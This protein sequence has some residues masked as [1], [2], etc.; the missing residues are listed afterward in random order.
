LVFALLYLLRSFF[1]LIF[2]TFIFSYIQASG[3]EKLASKVPN[4]TLRV[5]FVF[6]LFLGIIAAIFNFLAPRVQTQAEVFARKSPQYLQNLDSSLVKAASDYPFL[7]RVFPQIE[8]MRDADHQAGGWQI[9]RSVSARIV[10]DMFTLDSADGSTDRVGPVIDTLREIFGRIIASVSAFFL[11]L[12]FSFLIVLDLPHLS[13]SARGLRDT[14]IRVIYDEIAPTFVSFARVLGR[15]FEAQ[16]VIALLNTILTAIGVYMLG[17]GDNVAFF[18]LIVFLCSFIPVAGVFISSVP[19]CLLALQESGFT[20]MVLAVGM[21]TVI[22]MIEAYILNP[23]IYGH[24][25]RMNPV[26]VLIILTV[27]GK[28]FHM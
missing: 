25:L 8:E 10:K 5:V 24:H 13:R 27:A 22:H 4:R 18:S 1:L 12:L 3:V 9:Q 6:I 2:L 11:S 23:K 7:E 17:L 21:I 14:K 19:I 20:L 16:M 28:L 15:A 26:I